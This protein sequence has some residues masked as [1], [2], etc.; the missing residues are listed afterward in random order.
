MDPEIHRQLEDLLGGTAWILTDAHDPQADPGVSHILV[1]YRGSLY[2]AVL[3]LGS[4]GVFPTR[5]SRTTGQI[6]LPN[7]WQ[8]S[9]T[10]RS[11]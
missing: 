1:V 4:A 2:D 9:L 8:T 6:F 7:G 11:S 5:V 10:R 3:V